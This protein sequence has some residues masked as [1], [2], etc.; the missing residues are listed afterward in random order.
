MIL[1]FFE[2]LNFLSL[3]IVRVKPIKYVSVDISPSAATTRLV[4]SNAPQLMMVISKHG[5]YS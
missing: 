2:F 1:N 3:K 4:N 5:E